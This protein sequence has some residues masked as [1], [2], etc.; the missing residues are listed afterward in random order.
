MGTST[1]NPGQKGSTPLVPSWLE[2]PE[3]VALQT[4]INS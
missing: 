3:H 2:E 4:V 1:H